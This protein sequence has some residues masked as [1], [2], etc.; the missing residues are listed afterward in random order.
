MSEERCMDDLMAVTE[1]LRRLADQLESDPEWNIEVERSED[2]GEWEVWHITVYFP[3]HDDMHK[4]IG[5]GERVIE[6]SNHPSIPMEL[7][8]DVRDSMKGG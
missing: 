6:V 5:K 4:R 1:G 2:V 3:S 7:R 8:R